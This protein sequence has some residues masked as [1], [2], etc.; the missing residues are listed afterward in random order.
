MG[1]QEGCACAVF[2]KLNT[3]PP[4]VMHT[5]WRYSDIN[6]KVYPLCHPP[7]PP[8]ELLLNSKDI[9]GAHLAYP[10]QTSFPP[11][12]MVISFQSFF[13]STSECILC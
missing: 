2:V 9:L 12:K 6:L 13:M 10:K 4:Q 3:L 11:M 1:H 7:P 5:Y 8:N